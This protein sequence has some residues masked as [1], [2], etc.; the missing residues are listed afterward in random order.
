MH[1]T[2]HDHFVAALIAKAKELKLGDPLDYETTLGP[3]ISLH[4]A[5]RIRKQ[6]EDAGM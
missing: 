5:A 3:V 1:E 4:S 2:I 6:V